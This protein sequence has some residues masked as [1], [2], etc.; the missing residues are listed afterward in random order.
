[1]INW[2]TLSEREKVS[3]LLWEFR[4]FDA[5]LFPVEE[6]WLFISS[7]SSVSFVAFHTDRI[8]LT[9]FTKDFHEMPTGG[10]GG[11]PNLVLP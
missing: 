1:M 7:V 8:N 10:Q 5:R 4:N 11:V 6:L 2:A 9:P 3:E